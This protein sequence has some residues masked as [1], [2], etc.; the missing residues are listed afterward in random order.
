MNAPVEQKQGIPLTEEELAHLQAFQASRP[1]WSIAALAERWHDENQGAKSHTYPP[2]HPYLTGMRYVLQ[3]VIPLAPTKVLDI[4]SPLA[5]SVAL[6]C[7][8]GIDLTMLDVRT[9][10]HAA[11]LGLKWHQGNATQM[12]YDDDSWPVVTSMWV[13]GHVGD[14]RYGDPFDIDGDLRYLKEIHRVCSDTA[15]IGI[16]LVDLH[17]SNIFNLH[18]IYSWEWLDAQFKKV[19]FTMTEHAALPVSADAYFDPSFN[20][21]GGVVR[22]DGFYGVATLRK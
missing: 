7:V 19:G 14:G 17:C 9:H 13:M 21:K 2:S 20:D 15:I 4:G 3:R 16:G 12:P 11:L 8:P 5:Q 1:D 6:S 18:R 10:P 22:S